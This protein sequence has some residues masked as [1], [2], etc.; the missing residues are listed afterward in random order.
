MFWYVPAVFT[1][2]HLSRAVSGDYVNVF[3][4]LSGLDRPGRDDDGI[5]L[6][7]EL[8]RN[9]DKLTWPKF[10]VFIVEGGLQLE[11]PRRACRRRCR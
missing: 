5:L 2:T 3:A 4:L 11:H 6:G 7:R 8:Q 9:I 10:A 1:G